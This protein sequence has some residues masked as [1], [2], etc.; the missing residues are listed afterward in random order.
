MQDTSY[1]R[2]RRIVIKNIPIPPNKFL[3]DYNINIKNCK[4]NIRFDLLNIKKQHKRMSIKTKP[5]EV[6]MV[7][8]W[9]LK[10]DSTLARPARFG[11]SRL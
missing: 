7:L 2:L 1:L 11:H 8:F 9:R 6:R 10:Q 4:T 3:I 5:P